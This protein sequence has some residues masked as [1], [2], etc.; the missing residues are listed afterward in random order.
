MDSNSNLSP[1][2]KQ[3]F[4]VLNPVYSELR[5]E[6]QESLENLIHLSNKIITKRESNDDATAEID[7][8]N[9][10]L[11]EIE[12]KTFESTEDEEQ[13]NILINFFEK[14]REIINE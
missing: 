12:D 11:D 10:L 5:K 9:I 8:F 4:E 2:A 1:V 6:I 3:V 14:L 7:E 13:E